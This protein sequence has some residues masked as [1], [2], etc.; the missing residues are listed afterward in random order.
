[1]DPKLSNNIRP[2]MKNRQKLRF[3]TTNEDSMSLEKIK[4]F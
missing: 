3:D 4:L 1:M 2:S